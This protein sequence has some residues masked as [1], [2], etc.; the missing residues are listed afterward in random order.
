MKWI[1]GL[2]LKF[3]FTHSHAQLGEYA[4]Q[5]ESIDVKKGVHYRFSDF[6]EGV[7]ARKEATHI[8]ATE[9]QPSG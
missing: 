2:I 3:C 6:K 1:V 5:S 9:L 7:I 4:H 8:K